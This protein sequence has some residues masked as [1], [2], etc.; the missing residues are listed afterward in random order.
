MTLNRRSLLALAAGSIAPAGALLAP[1]AR[2]ADAW[3]SHPIRWIVAYPAAGG[4]DFLARQVAPEMGRLLGQ[5]L[6]V[7]NRPGA[8]GII[9]TEAASK[10]PGDGYTI[11]TGD[12][13]AMVYHTA[14]YKKLPYDPK[15]FV[16]LGF[17]ASFPLVLVA[18]PQSGFTSARQ[19]LDE[20]RR[21]PGK[22]S[23]ASPGAGSPHHL[24]MELIKERTHTFIVH[25]PY[26]GTTPAMQDVISGQVPMMV[27]DTAA[28]LAQIRAGKLRALAVLTKRRIPQLPDVPALAE[29]GADRGLGDY[30]A[31]AWQGL[32]APKGTPPDIANRLTAAM[33]QAILSPAVK[34]TLEDFGL[35]VAP[36]DGPALAAFIQKETVFWHKLIADRRLSLD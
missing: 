17:M 25:V 30:E 14:L 23:Y 22:Y 10:Q 2:A 6:V 9:G 36:T 13:G 35:D 27:V 20:V 15:D 3:P 7:D 26:R 28:G 31:I 11:L 1:G 19:L 8:A 21:N 33:H 16:P 5:T 34:K 4:S 32:F 12:N 29:I 24:A 18:N